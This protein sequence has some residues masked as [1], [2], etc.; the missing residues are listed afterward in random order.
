[1]RAVRVAVGWPWPPLTSPPRAGEQL[2]APLAPA[3]RP[4]P[5]P[6]TRQQITPHMSP[7]RLSA[8]FPARSPALSGEPGVGGT[9]AIECPR[10]G[11]ERMP[12]MHERANGY[13]VLKRSE[14][15]RVGKESRNERA[16]AQGNT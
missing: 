6:P 7:A 9:G 5:P 15:R 4:T 14:E 2:L 16:R 3:R 12:E 10:P 1:M 8:R 11:A 13:I